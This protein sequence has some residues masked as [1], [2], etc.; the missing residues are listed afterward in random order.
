MPDLAHGRA[1]GMA[2]QPSRSAGT[3]SVLFYD[4]YMAQPLTETPTSIETLIDLVTQV[5]GDRETAL[6]WMGT[7]VQALESARI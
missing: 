1:A 7:P 5:V 3:A 4:K 2:I 6:R